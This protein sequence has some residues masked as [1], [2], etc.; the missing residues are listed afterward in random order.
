MGH[1]INKIRHTW[2]P[3]RSGLRE[4]GFTGED[5]RVGIPNCYMNADED[6]RLA[7]LAGLIESDGNI[8]GFGAYCRI[9]KSMLCWLTN[10]VLRLT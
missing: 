5:R 4:L 10:D 7:V 3:I 6:S 8:F 9:F 1:C 2:N